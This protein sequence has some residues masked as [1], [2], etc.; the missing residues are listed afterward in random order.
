MKYTVDPY[1]LDI[2]VDPG[3]SENSNDNT[4]E[5]DFVYLTASDQ[6]HTTAIGIKL[7]K[8]DQLLASAIIAATGGGTGIH[9]HSQVI[10][11]NQIVVCCSDTV[12]CLS[13]PD[14]SLLWQT[15][16]DDIT[17]FEIY[18][19]KDSYIVHGEL[20]IS[21]LE[22]NGKILWQK[23]GADIFTTPEGDSS[24][25]LT[26][27]LIVVKDWENRVYKFDYEGNDQSDTFNFKKLFAG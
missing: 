8:I 23:S 6:R 27:D 25:Q 2:F 21:R 3:F 12:F 20:E 7:Y 16:V 19:Y 15:K 22:K 13:I 18:K 9:D 14:L 11:D 17:C 4:N 5:Y 1:L 10:E 24:L 26:N